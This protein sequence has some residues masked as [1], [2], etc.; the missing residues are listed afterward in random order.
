MG[1]MVMMGKKDD[2]RVTRGGAER[3]R[4]KRK[5]KA[6]RGGGWMWLR[7]DM[8]TV[9]VPGKDA[10]DMRGGNL[11]NALATLQTEPRY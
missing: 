8:W 9:G 7:V 1:W 4:V 10:K 3:Q 11:C 6:Q 5:K 2:R